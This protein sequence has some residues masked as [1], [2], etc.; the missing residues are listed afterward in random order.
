MSHK[1]NGNVKL[2]SRGLESLPTQLFV[3]QL[4]LAEKK[5]GTHYPYSCEEDPV[6][7]YTKGQKCGKYSQF[8]YL[9]CYVAFLVRFM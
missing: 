8:I 9:C 5:E 3:K 7:P 6:A 4:V 1:H 2:L